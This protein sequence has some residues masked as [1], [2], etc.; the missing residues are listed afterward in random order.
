MAS[1]SK[2]V[3]TV[4]S[5]EFVDFPELY[6]QK[7]PA[8]VDTGADSSTIWTS[9]IKKTTDDQLAFVL[10][11]PG[12]KFFTGSLIKTKLFKQTLV[13]NSSGSKELRYKVKLLLVIN[14][15]KIRTW[16]T[17][18]DREGMQYPV[19]LGRRLLKNKFLVDVSK[20][21]IRGK[22]KPSRVLILGSQLP[23]K[24]FLKTVKSQMQNPVELIGR[25][26]DQ[27]AFWLDK[28]NVKVSETVTKLD[29]RD[30]DLV[31]FKSHQRHYE[32]A[33]AAAEY[34]KFH[35][36][37][38]LNQ[39]LLDQV[40][41]DKLAESM[42]LVLNGI[43]IPLT[44]CGS[45]AVLKQQAAEIVS[46]LGKPFVCKEINA[47]R[48]QKN[49][50]LQNVSDIAKVL[51]E[52]MPEDIYSLQRY[53]PNQ[54]YIRALV[55]GAEV[56][57]LIKRSSVDNEDARKMHLNTPTGSAN[58]TLVSINDSPLVLR[59]LASRTASI[60][61]RKVAGIDLIKDETTGKWLVLDVNGAPQIY[62]GAFTKEKRMA[63]A[64]YL[65][66]QLEK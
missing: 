15:R 37:H 51:T 27:L 34:L 61:H 30:F 10:F 36:V 52:S 21:S 49:F 26:F 7:I 28:D 46:K 4:G 35:H 48:S 60:M 12:S 14:G 40:A 58:A 54:G 62:S 20:V 25:S 38:F 3:K 32:F 18:A 29:I 53:I 2:L 16:F 19:L 43:P 23:N 64:K 24:E 17:L 65:D 31:Y 50:L 42:R 59:E 9:R 44:F 63:F 33:I 41:Y 39:E 45:Q 56:A 47:T 66:N 57:L 8:K 1:S 22:G 55:L 5:K 11:G 6:L 13:K